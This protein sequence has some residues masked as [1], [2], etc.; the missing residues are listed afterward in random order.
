M[1]LGRSGTRT[2]P[3]AH[4]GPLRTDSPRDPCERECCGSACQSF[5]RPARMTRR[6]H[7]VTQR[8]RQGDGLQDA[9]LV[10]FSLFDRERRSS[11]LPDQVLDA[12]GGGGV[13]RRPATHIDPSPPDTALRD[14]CDSADRMAAAPRAA[15]GR[16]DRFVLGAY[17]VSTDW[18]ASLSSSCEFGSRW[19]VPSR[20]PTW[21]PWPPERLASAAVR[22]SYGTSATVAAGE[23]M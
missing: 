7:V 21:R 2:R 9:A 13:S 17:L 20:W 23:A 14:G 3:V 16:P 11:G 22:E 5:C 15:Q 8:A 10:G 18:F 6:R 12:A 19:S 1:G 4:A